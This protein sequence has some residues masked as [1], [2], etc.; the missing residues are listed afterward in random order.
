MWS[1]SR[2]LCSSLVS[3]REE[4]AAIT[5]QILLENKYINSATSA[6]PAKKYY[7]ISG[8]FSLSNQ[9]CALAAPSGPWHLT[10]TGEQKILAF[11]VD[12]IYWVPRFHRFRALASLQLFFL[13]HSLAQCCKPATFPGST[14]EI[15]N[16]MF[17]L[18]ALPQ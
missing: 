2:G 6:L 18:L 10:Y 11:F 13:E 4:P 8:T 1:V 16:R 15:L 3:H 12:V 5:A 14:V 9:G 7:I 17:Y